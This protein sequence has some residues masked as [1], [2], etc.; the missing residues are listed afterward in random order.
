MSNRVY[1]DWAF[2]NELP[3]KVSML[4]FRV[5]CARPDNTNG[6]KTSGPTTT[7]TTGS[8]SPLPPAP[9]IIQETGNEPVATSFNDTPTTSTSA[10]LTNDISTTMNTY[11]QHHEPDISAPNTIESHHTLMN[12]NVHHHGNSRHNGNDVDRLNHESNMV[13]SW[14]KWQQFESCPTYEYAQHFPFTD[15]M[16]T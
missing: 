8:Y 15:W 2:T 3:S 1:Q 11:N 5:L 9:V 6:A 10:S 13:P 16:A 14:I 12:E 4:A 7:T